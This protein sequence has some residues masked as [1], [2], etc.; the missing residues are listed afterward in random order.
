MVKEAEEFS[1]QDEVVRKTVEARNQ[2]EN[3]LFSLKSQLTDDS[4]LGGKLESDDKE[5]LLDE[6]RTRQDWLDANAA[7]ASLDDLEEQREAFQAVVSPITSKLY[8][9]AGGAGGDDEPLYGHDE[10]SSVAAR[11][12][13]FRISFVHNADPLCLSSALMGYSRK[14]QN[15]RGDP[16]ILFTPFD[17]CKE[18][19][20]EREPCLNN[21][22]KNQNW[23]P[24]QYEKEAPIENSHYSLS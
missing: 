22:F 18:V 16:V 12:P 15:H 3:A 1:E 17:R 20:E 21:A 19:E 5:T 13:F 8:G 4:G 7:T 6:I 10:V 23:P 14:T 9:G 2:L 11:V 24:P